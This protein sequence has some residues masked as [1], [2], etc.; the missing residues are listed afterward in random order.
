MV[1]HFATMS[2]LYAMLLWKS[3]EHIM[4]K[5]TYEQMTRPIAYA[6]MQMPAPRIGPPN[7][8]TLSHGITMSDVSGFTTVA[9]KEILINPFREQD[10]WGNVASPLHLSMAF[11]NSN[12]NKSSIERAWVSFGAQLLPSQEAVS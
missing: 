7:M 6:V 10:E 5:T 2:I 11:L 12:L 9:S 1:C 3:E 4:C 8:A